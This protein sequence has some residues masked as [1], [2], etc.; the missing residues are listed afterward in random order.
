LSKP[1]QKYRANS[2]SYQLHDLPVAP[3]LNKRERI[4]EDA[5]YKVVAVVAVVLLPGPSRR[6]SRVTIHNSLVADI[7][8]AVTNHHHPKK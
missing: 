5:V 1:F 8:K 4:F 7:L 2:K 3:K 6:H